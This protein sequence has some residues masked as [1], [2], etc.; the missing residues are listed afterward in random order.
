MSSPGNSTWFHFSIPGGPD[1]AVFGFSGVER[2]SRPYSFTIDLASQFAS[3]R[4]T[5]LVGQEAYLSIA[6]RSGTSRLVHGIIREM[7]QLHSAN[8]WTCYRCLIVPRLW[9]LGSRRNHRIFQHQTVPAIITHILGEQNFTEDA[10]AFKCFHDYPVRE[11]CVQYGESDLH[12]ISRLCE[13]EGIYYYFEHSETGHCLCFSDMPGGPRINGE[14]DLRYFPGSGQTADTAVVS[15]ATLRSQ[16]VSDRATLRDWNFLT[17]SSLLEGSIDEPDFLKAPT[18]P[19]M[20]AEIYAYPHIHQTDSEAGRYADIQLLR[21]LAFQTWLEAESDVSRF[22]PGFTFSLHGHDLERLNAGWWITGVTHHGEQPQVLEHEAPDR[23]MLYASA[24]TAIPE[25][26]RYIPEIAHHKNRIMG[27]QTALVTGLDG[28]E[29][30]PDKYGRVKVQF[31]W[32]REGTRDENTSCWIR[33]SQDWAGT[34]FGT[35][36]IPRV[37]HEVIVSFLEGD[38]DR[39][40]ITGRTY[41]GGNMPPYELPDHKTRTVFKSMSTPGD[42][43]PR[44]FNE[45]RIEDKADEEEIYIHAEKDVNIHVKNDWKKHIL[46]DR[47]QTVDR[48]VYDEIQGET[49]VI[50]KDQRKTE[51]FFDDHLTIHADSHARVEQQWLMK[52]GAELHI[53]TGQRMLLEAGSE[54]TVKAGGSWLKLDAS[55]ARIQ[56]GR[57]DIMGGGK[58]GSATSA[59]PLLPVAPI[60]KQPGDN[61]NATSLSPSKQKDAVS[62]SDKNKKATVELEVEFLHSTNMEN[63]K[64]VFQEISNISEDKFIWEEKP[65]YIL[66]NEDN[67]F[68]NLSVHDKW[69]NSNITHVDRLGRT[70]RIVVRFKHKLSRCVKVEIVPIN[71]DTA[72]CY[73]EGEKQRSASFCENLFGEYTTDSTGMIIVSDLYINSLGGNKYK[74]KA[75]DI[76]SGKEAYSHGI[77]ICWKYLWVQKYLCADGFWK[78]NS[79]PFNYLNS[80]IMEYKKS[81]INIDVSLP[82][83]NIKGYEFVDFDD[84]KSRNAIQ[85]EFITDPEV[86]KKRPYITSAVVCRAIGRHDNLVRVI[87]VKTGPKYP[88][89]SIPVPNAFVASYSVY[90]ESTGKYEQNKWI[91]E[92]RYGEKNIDH[93]VTCGFVDEKPIDSEAPAFLATHIWVDVSKLEP[94]EGELAIKV[95]TV[96]ADFVGR[97]WGG[98]IHCAAEAHYFPSHNSASKLVDDY[99]P[100]MPVV[101]GHEIGHWI[102]MVS[103]GGPGYPDSHADFYDQHSAKDDPVLS[104]HVGPHCKSEFDGRSGTCLMFGAA[105]HISFCKNCLIMSRKLSCMFSN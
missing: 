30:Y 71:C 83:K 31:F 35:Q 94:G 8:L 16:S 65:A 68:I 37:G 33:A 36:A 72:S 60:Q 66:T 102:G 100:R 105:G 73:S 28:E 104:N 12:F 20:D 54:L 59:A 52:A 89:L 55:G 69:L 78:P 86:T 77:I 7:E 38:P 56:G 90:N 41:H 97:H 91:L 4:L 46:R 19:G 79:D 6:D 40:V 49:H 92:A 75:I 80:M 23:G 76:E 13:E 48:N 81:Y 98:I 3:E 57:I 9:F 82:V 99:L 1:F 21:Q 62:A 95:R 47:H 53:E 63:Y 34:E 39:P 27:T 58:A 2:I 74:V 93:L 44:G 103:N 88:P 96:F 24:I 64:N 14:S 70:P 43:G 15:R 17:P 85:K 18:A 51:L 45:L 84:P 42:D 50:L 26:V 29:I 5:N 101:L 11:Y 61:P 25:D 10:F 22:L 87:R 32:D 67:Q